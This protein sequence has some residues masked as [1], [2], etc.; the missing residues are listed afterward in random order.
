[1]L[2]APRAAAVA[3]SDRSGNRR[4]SRSD[5]GPRDRAVAL[6]DRSRAGVTGSVEHR[7]LETGHVVE[8][9]ALTRTEHDPGRIE[10]VRGPAVR[11]VRPR[12]C[13]VVGE[14]D[15]SA[16]VDRDKRLLSV[17]EVQDVA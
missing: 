11:A 15:W 5:S 4:F 16:A 12:R 1:M 14:I 10:D 9:H 13:P 6:D 7:P 8:G 2:T 17:G 3:T